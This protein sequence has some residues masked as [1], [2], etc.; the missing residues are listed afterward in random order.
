MR[1]FPSDNPKLNGRGNFRLRGNEAAARIQANFDA[2]EAGG[3][4]PWPI[5]EAGA[6]G[7]KME[8]LVW[9]EATALS[10]WLRESVSLLAFP[11]VLVLHT[12][13]MGFLAGAN[14]AIDLRVLGVASGV[15][16]KPME[17]FFPVMWIAFAVNAVSGVLLLIAYPAKALTNP[18]FY[19]KILL[20][21]L[22]IG[23][24]QLLR[25]RVFRD[26]DLD[27]GLVSRR[28]RVLASASLLLWTAVITA[29]RFLAYTYTYLTAVEAV[30]NK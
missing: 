9:L 8:Y 11:L 14:A 2:R 18:L 20:I 1:V 17:R 28:G 10:T 29:G 30:A 15:P 7:E 22:A 27:L 25:K 4:E 6:R 23:T 3:S 21:G 12:V 24:A 19:V 16:L 5:R 26:P 13:G